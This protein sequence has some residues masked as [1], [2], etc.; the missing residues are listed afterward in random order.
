MKK[1]AGQKKASSEPIV[2][3]NEDQSIDKVRDILFGAQT[4][5]FDQRIAQMDE[6]FSKQ[7]TELR[8]E[9]VRMIESL[10]T[11]VKKEV[12]SLADDLRGE[13]DARS[14]AV[15]KL[16]QN[17][18]NLE[19]DFEKKIQQLGKKTTEG[20]RDLQEQI[21]KQ[22]KDLL[23]EIRRRFDEL[24]HSMDQAIDGLQ[25]DKTDRLALANL[26]TELAL[27]LKD[28]FQLPGTDIS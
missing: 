8:N 4:R 17:A 16:T 2:P 23:E 3:G 1:K 5:Q 15:G 12:A 22:S 9:T 10:E 13:G 28:E 27:R 11:Y 25:E 19:N 24:S 26:F 21:L 14:Q 7:L 6:R 18:S 20:Q